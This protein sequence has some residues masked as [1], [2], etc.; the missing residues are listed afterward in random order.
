MKKIYLILIIA[1]FIIFSF[2]IFFLYLS[3][4]EQVPES[5]IENWKLYENNE[6]GYSFKYPERFSV[7]QQLARGYVGG[8]ILGDPKKGSSIIFYVVTTPHPGLGERIEDL[9]INGYKATLS[10]SMNYKTG[11]NIYKGE[12]LIVIYLKNANNKITKS[13]EDLFMKIVSSIQLSN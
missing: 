10:K 3:N 1:V 9:E 4:Q 5:P 12:N 6:F 7:S 13:D 2:L 11:I 8:N